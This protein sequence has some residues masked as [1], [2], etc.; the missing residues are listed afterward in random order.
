MVIDGN[1]AGDRNSGGMAHRHGRRDEEVSLHQ[2]LMVIMG[3]PSE[4]NLG[5]KHAL[6]AQILYINDVSKQKTSIRALKSELNVSERTVRRV[7]SDLRDQHMINST[8]GVGD[9]TGLRAWVVR[10]VRERS[11][12][13]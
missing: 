6:A 9:I 3:I 7:V 10:R 11:T 8:R 13:G 1:T 2:A 4:Y 5:P 12:R